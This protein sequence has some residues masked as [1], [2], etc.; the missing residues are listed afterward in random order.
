MV[1][2]VDGTF[3]EDGDQATGQ[4]HSCERDWLKSLGAD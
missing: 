3:V 1:C 4:R 2:V